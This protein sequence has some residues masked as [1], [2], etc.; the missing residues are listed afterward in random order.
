MY[1]DVITTAKPALQPVDPAAGCCAGPTWTLAEYLR[2]QVTAWFAPQFS[3]LRRRFCEGGE[4]AFLASLARCR[5]WSAAGGKSRAY[6]AKTADDR[7]AS[8][9][10]PMACQQ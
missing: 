6:F 3:E 4:E 5:P 9:P 7:C 1:L 2:L 10:G 8:L